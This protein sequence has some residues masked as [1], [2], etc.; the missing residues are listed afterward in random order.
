MKKIYL[1][2]LFQLIQFHIYAEG[3]FAEYLVNRAT[4]LLGQ[5]HTDEFRLRPIGPAAFDIN[6]A[7]IFVD[8]RNGIII[9]TEIIQTFD[10]F[11][12][13]KDFY[14]IFNFYFENSNWVYNIGG[15]DYKIFMFESIY[16]GLNTP[17]RN[18]EGFIQG[19]IGFSKDI[20]M[21]TP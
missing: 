1:L 14:N 19:W 16:A 6:N 21:L 12:D 2:I 9:G 7:E 17:I 11:D 8:V 10:T 18:S 5:P 13:A 20:Q 4:L 3:N 15:K